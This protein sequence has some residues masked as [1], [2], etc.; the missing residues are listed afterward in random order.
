MAPGDRNRNSLSVYFIYVLSTL[1]GICI[2]AAQIVLA[3]YALKLGANPLAVG[4]LAATFS[5]F[6]TCGNCGQAGRPLWCTL[7]DDIRCRVQWDRLVNALLVSKFIRAVRDGHDVRSR[8][9]FFQPCNAKLGRTAQH[10]EEPSTVLQQL[11]A[12]KRCSAVSGAAH[13]RIPD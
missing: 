2:S 5:I 13:G 7:A 6:P 12:D 11:H 1:N 8:Y 9:H 4:L 10:T 3:L